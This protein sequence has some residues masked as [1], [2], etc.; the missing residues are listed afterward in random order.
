MCTR[1]VPARA[2]RVRW[3]F[4]RADITP[5]VG[6]H[7]RMWGAAK[8]DRA[9]GI[10]K[11]LFGDVM[12]IGPADGTCPEL[13]WALLD[14]TDLP[15]AHHSQLQSAMAQASGLPSGKAVISC[16]HTHASGWFS[17]ERI[18]L[19]GGD[20]IPPYL[21]Q[22]QDRLQT[23]ARQAV[24]NMQP[25][26][27]TYAVGRCRMAADRDYWDELNGR[28]VCGLNPDVAADDTVLVARI[29]D[30]SATPLAI[31]VN[32]ACH[33]TTLAY[34]NTEISPDFV[35]AMREEVTRITGVPCVFAQG[36]SGDLGPRYDYVGGSAVAD[37]NGRCLAYA[38]L[39]A[40]ESMG[41][42]STDYH[43]AGPVVSGA[44]LGIWEHVPF[45]AERMAQVAR[46]AGGVCSI[47]L[48]LKP[49]P[50]P[51]AV[52]Q[53]L[54]QWLDRQAQAAAEG[55]VLTARDC[56]ARAERARRS[57]ARL[58]TLPT[59]TSY[60]FHYS[61]YRLGDAIW[62]MCGGEPFSL[63]QTE[64]RARFADNAVLVSGLS[65]DS[66]AS[67]LLPTDYCGRGLYQKEPSPL[68]PGSLA[69]V[70]DAIVA[71]IEQLLG[72]EGRS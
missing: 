36:A 10:H 35:G 41:P 7:H 5:P 72:R 2:S 37:Q 33:P 12:A 14:L 64:L 44:T 55:D 6:I 71:Q 53:D 8:H 31:L 57:L 58:A 66:L 40:L 19:P 56:G 20:L 15:L 51:A 69:S 29:T 50:D 62:V 16:S 47:D 67:Y 34:E 24:A 60:P 52:Q 27:I 23:A 30:L 4:A 18:Q 25:V 61:V 65:G 38:A 48:P 17:P 46:F 3:G 70:I 68:A 13:L 22:M 54:E 26:D 28:F 32:Y 63:L 59:G 21:A 49:W 45:S 42:P 9:T 43:Y 39:S 11:P 1:A